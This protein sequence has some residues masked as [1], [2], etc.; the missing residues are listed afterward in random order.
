MILA[1]K[2]IDLRKKNGWSQEELAEKL[3]VSRQSISK[4]ESAQSVPD[5]GRILKLSQIFGVSTDYL[6]KDEIESIVPVEG[7]PDDSPAARTV[8]MEEANAFLR[9]RERNARSVALGVMM[10]ILSPLLLILLEGA[11]QFGFLTAC[12]RAASSTWRKRT[13]RPS[14]AWTAWCA[15]AATASSPPLP[16]SSRSASSSASWRFCRSS[17]R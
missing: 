4:W 6:L 17:S 12:A 3:D 11:R 5:M 9:L 8:T 15:S 7:L 1:D 13:S 14:T 10:C 16:G 2:I